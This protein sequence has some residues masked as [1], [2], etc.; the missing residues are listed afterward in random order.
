MLPYMLC[1]V[2]ERLRLVYLLHYALKFLYLLT[3]SMLLY[4]RKSR[5][6][7][8]RRRKSRSPSPR[9]RRSPS[10]PIPRR[11]RRQ[12][13][14]SSSLSPIPKSTSPSFE[15]PEHNTN[16]K[17]RK[18]EEEKKRYTQNFRSLLELLFLFYFLDDKLYIS[19][20]TSS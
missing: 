13:S 6:I 18:D 19:L 20:R 9:R 5:S 1:L 16:E 2:G 14:K 10:S 8:P 15:S 4:R 17:L 7:T 12:R 3:I 11:Y